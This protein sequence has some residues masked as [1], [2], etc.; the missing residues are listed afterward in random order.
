MSSVNFRLSYFEQGMSSSTQTKRAQDRQ[1]TRGSRTS[2]ETPEQV[3]FVTLPL[4]HLNLR[5]CR[6]ACMPH[7]S[8]T[9]RVSR[10]THQI[11]SELAERRGTS[12]S[13]LLDQLAESARRRHILGQYNA[14]MTELLTDPTERANW[15]EETALSEVSSADLAGERAST[16]AG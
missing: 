14:R 11:L 13:D 4:L 10:R 5:I 16:V 6:L 1:T 2:V 7:D 9:V 3:A 12:V 15:N 8:T